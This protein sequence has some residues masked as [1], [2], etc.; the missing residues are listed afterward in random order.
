MFS[1]LSKKL[2]IEHAIFAF[3]HCRDVVAAVSNSGG[4]GVLGAGWFSPEQLA[5]E[6]NW[7]DDHVT[8][9]YGVDI[10]IP[11]K[12]EGMEEIDP[13]ALEHRLWKQ[14]PTEH[15]DFANKLLSDQG[16][17]EWPKDMPHTEPT[18]PGATYATALPL[19]QEA[20][21]RPKCKVIVN[22]LGT[23]PDDVIEMVHNS[24][25]LIGA[26]CGKVKQAIAHKDAGLNFVVAQGSEGGGHTG[27]I[28]SIV[29]WPQIADAIK[30][31]PMLAAGG[32]G[33]GRQ[34]LAA[35]SSGAAGVWTGSLWLTVEEATSQPAQKESYLNATSE[36]TVRSRAWTG[37][38]AR[39][40]KNQWTDLWDD[41]ST[42]KPLGM[43]MQF[44]VSA[45][46]RRRTERYAGVAKAQAVAMNPAGQVIG[47]FNQVESC[48]VVIFR[49][50]TEYAD[51]LEHLNKLM[52]DR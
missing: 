4:M 8:G 26:L 1:E 30:P 13:D 38:P 34:M 24:G 15:I 17:P 6:L 48:R 36:D 33:N 12:Y 16:V 27:E 41:V 40:I 45:D 49:L 52:P 14:I 23:P 28:G 32:I 18:L 37:K 39:L 21:T 3:S 7:L 10:I 35:M 19:I 43:P 20:L 22:A 5:E 29:L 44:M 50:L 2:G 42:P 51:T 11:Q 31:L 46:A 47:Q 25:R 9:G